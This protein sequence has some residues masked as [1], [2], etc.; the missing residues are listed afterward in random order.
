MLLCRNEDLQ[1]FGCLI[2]IGE[3]GEALALKLAGSGTGDSHRFSSLA[4]G[5]EASS[6][7]SRRFLKRPADRAQ[8]ILYDRALTLVDLRADMHAGVQCVM[9]RL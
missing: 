3:L 9:L 4:G 6:S 8:Q 7:F 5:V 1:V 2:A